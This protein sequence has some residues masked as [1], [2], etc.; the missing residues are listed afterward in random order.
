MNQQ[1]LRNTILIPGLGLA[2][3][4]GACATPGQHSASARYSIECTAG[5]TFVNVQYGDSRLQVHPIANVHRGAALE[6]RLKPDRRRSDETDYEK[7]KVAIRGAEGKAPPAE[8]ID[9]EGSYAD[10]GG[11]LV[12]CVPEDVAV[13][14]YYYMIEVEKVGMLDPRADV[15]K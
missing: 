3:A 12:V 9:V 7:V 14:T 5:G 15:T 1:A 4:L 8:W 11:T 6:F 10:T 13:D 2:L